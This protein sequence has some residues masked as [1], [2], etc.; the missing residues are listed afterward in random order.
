MLFEPRKLKRLPQSAWFYSFQQ[1]RGIP[2]KDKDAPGTWGWHHPCVGMARLAEGADREGAQT[3]PRKRT[4]RSLGACKRKSSV[5]ASW[6]RLTTAVQLALFTSGAIALRY[7]SHVHCGGRPLNCG[8]CRSRRHA[9]FQYLRLS[10]CTATGVRAS[11][12]LCLPQL[13]LGASRLTRTPRSLRSSLQ[14]RR[15][16]SANH[17]YLEKKTLTPSRFIGNSSGVGTNA[18]LQAYPYACEKGKPVARRGRK[19]LGPPT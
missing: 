1:K 6:S 8:R 3:C 2:R 7:R 17:R 4:R 18:G 5:K 19:A 10:H 15:K 11:T 16:G 13:I 9:S 14:I 12:H